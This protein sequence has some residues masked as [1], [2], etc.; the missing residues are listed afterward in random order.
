MP[1]Q[2]EVEDTMPIGVAGQLADL[3][4]EENGDVAS[5]TSE[6]ASAEIPFGV[7]VK[8]GTADDGVLKLTATSN[9]LAGI[10]VFS[11]LYAKPDELG[12]T[13]LKPK[14]T[15]DVLTRGRI[16]VFPEDAVTPASEV[17]VR[18]VATGSEVAGAFRGTAD[19][20]DTIDLT[21]FARWRSSADAADA[22]VLEIDLNNAALAT[23]D[24]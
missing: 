21:A 12:D 17:H 19:G 11:H 22:A 18:A 20:T 16:I 2:T 10:T 7:M 15:F 5:A 9:K 14:V 8:P 4:T 13:G 23:A 6:E 24:T 3:W 1:P